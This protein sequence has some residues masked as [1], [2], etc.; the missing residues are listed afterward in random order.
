MSLYYKSLI[1]L[2][3]II[4]IVL[5]YLPTSIGY[6]K[7]KFIKRICLNLGSVIGIT[8]NGCW[9]LIKYVHLS[10]IGIVP[11]GYFFYKGFVKSYNIYPEINIFKSIISIILSFIAVLEI[12][13]FV[14]IVIV[15]YLMKKDSR[16]EIAN[17]SW[18]K[19]NKK[20]PFY[21]GIIKPIIYALFEVALYYYVLLYILND[22]LKLSFIYSFIAI[23]ILYAMGKLVF[24]KNKEQ[25]LIYGIWAFVLNFIGSCIMVYSNSIT[26][27]IALYLLY[28]FIIAFKE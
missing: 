28:S 24:T 26:L 8:P 27:T 9:N 22:Y 4:Y 5:L 2:F 23:G 20:Y 10:I 3:I 6:K 15:S 11:I 12:S 18:I 13:F 19:F 7:F 16:K 1:F 21:T 14:I 25:A 17:V